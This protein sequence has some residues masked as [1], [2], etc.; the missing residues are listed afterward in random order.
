LMS[1]SEFYSL[2]NYYGY[3]EED[4]R[5]DSIARGLLERVKRSAGLK[6]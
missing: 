4:R 6:I 3:E 1:R 5:V 2:I